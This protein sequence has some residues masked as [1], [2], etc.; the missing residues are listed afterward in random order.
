MPNSIGIR[1]Y[2]ITICK[3]TG[4]VE[5]AEG[6]AIIAEDFVYYAIECRRIFKPVKAIL[7]RAIKSHGRDYC[8]LS[9]RS[10]SGAGGAE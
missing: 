3:E 4:R 8:Y 6:D 5:I 7:R 10:E 1:S 2:P 9:L